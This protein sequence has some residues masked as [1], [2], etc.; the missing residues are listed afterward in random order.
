MKELRAKGTCIYAGGCWGWSR[1]V[2]GD[3]Y[4]RKG[5]QIREPLLPQGDINHDLRSVASNLFV[6]LASILQDCSWSAKWVMTQ[7]SLGVE[8]E[9]AR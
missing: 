7:S 5:W 6:A 3:H 2:T 4:S 8:T 9:S 1:G